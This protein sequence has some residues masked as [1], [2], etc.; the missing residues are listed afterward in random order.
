MAVTDQMLTEA[1]NAL[2]ALLT[3][4]AVVEFTDQNGE[5]I[6]YTAAKK[7]DLIAYIAWLKGELG[8]DVAPTGPMKVW[9]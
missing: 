8:L 1:Q 7:H 4:S 9:M 3:G 2:H 5:K 6:R